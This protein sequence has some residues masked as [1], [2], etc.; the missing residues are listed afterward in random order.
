MDIGTIVLGVFILGSLYMFFLA[1]TTTPLQTPWWP[2]AMA[3]LMLTFIALNFLNEKYKFFQ[4]KISMM[5]VSSTIVFNTSSECD[6]A[7]AVFILFVMFALLGYIYMRQD[8]RMRSE[9]EV[10]KDDNVSFSLCSNNDNDCGRE[11]VSSYATEISG[12]KVTINITKSPNSMMLTEAQIR[13]DI[14]TKIDS[15]L[16]KFET[17]SEP[18]QYKL[19]PSSMYVTIGN[20]RKLLGRSKF[21]STLFTQDGLHYFEEDKY[22]SAFNGADLASLEEYFVIV[23]EK[24]DRYSPEEKAGLFP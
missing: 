22:L 12:S 18:N 24:F 7:S 21:K 17:S 5:D 9:C 8:R 23:K 2:K 16:A 13:S 4:N 14:Q 15:I 10:Q 6:E 11:I 19:G 1:G 20:L 3:L